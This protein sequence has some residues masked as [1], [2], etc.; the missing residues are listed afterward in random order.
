[1]EEMA[2]QLEANNIQAELTG[3]SNIHVVGNSNGLFE[4]FKAILQNCV[5]AI[6]SGNITIGWTTQLG[7]VRIEITDNGPGITTDILPVIFD[8]FFSGR[9][10]GRG[11]GFGL[12]KA[13]RIAQIHHGSIEIENLTGD[14]TNP[15]GIRVTVH[16]PENREP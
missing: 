3:D 14:S 11:L 5:D 15:T 8:P 4:M 1:V 16:L 13:W 12:S 2:I 6:E 7:Q 9:E 10:A